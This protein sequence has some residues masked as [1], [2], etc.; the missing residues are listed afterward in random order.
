MKQHIITFDNPAGMTPP[1]D[2]FVQYT[3]MDLTKKRQQKMLEQAVAM[4]PDICNMV[5]L[6]AIVTEADSFTAN[7]ETLT[8]DGVD[9]H[10]VA[11]ADLKPDQL[12]KAYGYF[13]TIGKCMPRDDAG[14]VEILIVDTWGS[15]LVDI[16]R[17][18]LTKHLQALTP[19]LVLSPSF[20][21]GFYGVSREQAQQLKE[22]VDPSPIGMEVMDNALVLPQKSCAGIFLAADSDEGFP[23]D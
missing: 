8:L 7:G 12:R 6:Q 19:D 23:K 20:G 17:E 21:L 22:F 10:S 16:C 15:I 1:T 4:Y 2:L 11:F 9:F 18:Q 5:K 3:R 14:L 13:L